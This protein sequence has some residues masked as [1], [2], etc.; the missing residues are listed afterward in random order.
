MKVL[1]ITPSIGSEFLSDAISSVKAQV[2]SGQIDHLVVVDGSEYYDRVKE[3]S[4]G[5]KILV[6]P[7]NVGADGFYGHRIYAAMSHLI[8]KSYDYVFFLDEDNWFMPN[9]VQ[10][11]VDTAVAEGYQFSYALR[12]FYTSEG[13]FFADDN[14]GSLGQWKLWEHGGHH[15]VDT[16]A[17]CFKREFIEKYGY[18]WHNGYAADRI[19][20]E[21]VKN[22]TSHGCTGKRTV[23][24]MLASP[25]AA[26]YQEELD[27]ILQN[28]EL[29][30]KK[31]PDGYPWEK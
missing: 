8:H 16:N 13:V 19:F 29:A 31:Y 25:D 5:V 10:S 11:C 24:Y 14:C 20:Y 12:S 6:L 27:F 28:N 3:L 17:Y 23:A 9:H 15:L 22:G 18:L 21:T 30:K 7:D 4:A 2:Y 1:V 26:K